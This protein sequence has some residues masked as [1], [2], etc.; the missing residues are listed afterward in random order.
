MILVYFGYH[1][2][3]DKFSNNTGGTTFGVDIQNCLQLQSAFQGHGVVVI[4]AVEWKIVGVRAP[5]GDG[6]DV[7]GLLEVPWTTAFR[8][9]FDLGGGIVAVP[10]AANEGPSL[11]SRTLLSLGP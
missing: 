2:F 8:Y 4:A 1:R 3:F 10:V 11:I 5:G 9:E 7:V 6:V